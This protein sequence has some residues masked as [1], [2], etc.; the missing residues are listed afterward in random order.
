[1]FLDVNYV[2][3]FHIISNPNNVKFLK[4]SHNYKTKC[5]TYAKLLSYIASKIY[6]AN[7]SPLIEI[8]FFH[9]KL[10]II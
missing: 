10:W 2:I 9:N 4:C 8:Y 1:M 6:Q 7:S 3:L 5:T